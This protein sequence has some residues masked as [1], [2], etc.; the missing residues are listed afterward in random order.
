MHLYHRL[1]RRTHI[2]N[3]GKDFDKGQQ[4]MKSRRRFGLFFRF[5]IRQFIDAMEYPQRQRSSAFRAAAVMFSGFFGLKADSAFPVTIQMIFAFL[6]KEFKG[7]FE[8]GSLLI[9][10]RRPYCG[11]RDFGIEYIRF[12]GDFFR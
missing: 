9:R 3:F 8:P 1:G 11:K 2:H 4:S 6:R 12:P 5:P 10:Q 7:S